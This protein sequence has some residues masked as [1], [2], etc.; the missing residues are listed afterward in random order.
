[1]AATTSNRNVRSKSNTERHETE[2][3]KE[4]T[5]DVVDYLAT[6][7]RENPGYAALACI[8]VG[9]VLGWKLKPW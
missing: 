7:A 5:Q 8:G 6:Y 1:M 2:S 4:I 3:P 9:F